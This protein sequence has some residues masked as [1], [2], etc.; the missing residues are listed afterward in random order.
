MA[1]SPS[2]LRYLT[3]RTIFGV[4]DRVGLNRPFRSNLEKAGRAMRYA[5]N[6]VQYYKPIYEYGE[7]LVKDR[8]NAMVNEFQG[9]VPSGGQLPTNDGFLAGVNEIMNQ[10]YKNN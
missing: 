10:T 9:D 1:T 2:G 5:M 4:E 6:T 3:N 7:A 8:E